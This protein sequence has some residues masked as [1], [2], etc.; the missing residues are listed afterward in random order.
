L[1]ACLHVVGHVGRVLAYPLLT[2]CVLG[3]QAAN[4]RNMC[5][6][7]GDKPAGS[8]WLTQ[9][10]VTDTNGQDARFI[11]SC[12]VA[13][14][15]SGAPMWEWRD[16]QPGQFYLR[17]VMAFESCRCCRADCSCCEQQFNGGCAV[18]ALHY[19]SILG[20]R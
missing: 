11:N 18:N 4:Q 15:Q 13:P 19:Q 8:Q 2:M 14:G 12:D 5:I 1:H 6:A 17:A 16:K 10:N 3:L 9:C 7:A 20:W